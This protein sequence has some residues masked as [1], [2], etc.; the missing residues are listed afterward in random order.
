[1]APLEAGID[2][3]RP[4]GDRTR[5]ARRRPRVLEIYALRQILVHYSLNR[6]RHLPHCNMFPTSCLAGF[7]LDYLISHDQG[8]TRRGPCLEAECAGGLRSVHVRRCDPAGRVLNS[9]VAPRVTQEAPKQGPKQETR[10]QRAPSQQTQD[11]TA[12]DGGVDRPDTGE[13]PLRCSSFRRSSF[14]CSSVS[15]GSAGM[16]HGRPLPP[17]RA[18][19]KPCGSDAPGVRPGATIP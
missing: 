11:K 17:S 12:G 18:S 14:R 3:V 13:P 1:M 7:L 16:H 5:K 15:P 9:G 8:G 4:A 10:S 2:V 6:S 19:V